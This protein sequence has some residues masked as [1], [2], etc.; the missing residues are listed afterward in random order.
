[1]LLSF[2]EVEKVS[3]RYPGQTMPAL[4]DVSFTANQGEIIA[5]LG[6]SGAGKTTLLR[7]MAGLESPDSGY[8]WLD[9]RP[10]PDLRQKLVPGDARVALIQQDFGLFN[11]MNVADNL[12]YPIL[13]LPF[14]RQQTRIQELL[15]LMRLP[16]IEKKMPAQLSGGERQRIAIARALASYP[17]LLLMDEPFSQ[18]D[19]PMRRSLR[20]DL[21]KIIL[22]DQITVVLVTHEP[23]H[24]LAVADKLIVMRKGKILQMGTPEEVYRY[25]NTEYVA[26]ATGEVNILP[27]EALPLEWCPELDQPYSKFCIRPE[28]MAIVTEKESPI[29]GTAIHSEFAGAYRLVT[30]LLENGHEVKVFH[31]GRVPTAGAIVGVRVRRAHP[32]KA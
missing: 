6:E 4:S 29:R 5:I 16:G 19:Y 12:S 9:G 25:P 17:R 2:L 20:R 26:A 24:A 21:K 1:M 3:K 23:S 11:R 22:R 8:V 10:V 18:M 13:S 32:L 30:V 14:E 28:E 7:I 15:E 27:T 31:V